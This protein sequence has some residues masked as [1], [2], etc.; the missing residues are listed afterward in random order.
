MNSE[1]SATSSDTPT[2]PG[3]RPGLR[4]TQEGT[5]RV[6]RGVVAVVIAPI[7]AAS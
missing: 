2:P 6:K 5:S 1:T 3:S 7:I 4:T